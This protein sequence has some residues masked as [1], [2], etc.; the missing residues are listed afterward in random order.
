M[1]C[2]QHT[3]HSR[4]VHG[5]LRACSIYWG[6]GSGSFGV[7]VSLGAEF[8]RWAQLGWAGNGAEAGE[9]EPP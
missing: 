1:R 6:S 4:G 2:T 8:P 5:A 3:A 7:K 9:E